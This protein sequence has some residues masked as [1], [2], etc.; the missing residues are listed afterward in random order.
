MADQRREPSVQPRL[1]G[2]SRAT[3]D[4]NPRMNFASSLILGDA[5]RKRE[6][7]K[8]SRKPLTTTDSAVTT[9]PVY[10]RRIGTSWRE[11][12]PVLYPQEYPRRA[13]SAEEGVG[14]R[15]GQRRPVC[16][17]FRARGVRPCARNRH[18]DS[19]RR[20]DRP[21]EVPA[22]SSPS[23]ALEEEVRPSG[24]TSRLPFL[25]NDLLDALSAQAGGASD[26]VHV[27]DA[28]WPGVHA[29]ASF[30]TGATAGRSS[31]IV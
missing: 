20:S 27:S 21:G 24:R 12:V 26:V 28:R 8:T 5:N 23:I 6:R 17:V 16:P 11:P 18:G 10:H 4:P 31:T 13:D 30:A 22:S 9:N 1:R 29:A 14:Q 7:L 15:G 19:S 3:G 25:S 2:T